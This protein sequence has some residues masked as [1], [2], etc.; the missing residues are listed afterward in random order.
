M[1]V[2][3]NEQISNKTK[4]TATNKTNTK[5]SLLNKIFKIQHLSVKWYKLNNILN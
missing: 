3:K 2:G 5:E 4:F 1:V